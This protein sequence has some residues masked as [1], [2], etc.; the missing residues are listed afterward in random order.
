MWIKSWRLKK[1]DAGGLAQ[2]RGSGG[3]VMG[4]AAEGESRMIPPPTEGWVGGGGKQASSYSSNLAQGDFS[5][6]TPSR[7]KSWTVESD[8]TVCESFS[9]WLTV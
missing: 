5:G 7:G 1:V 3:K 8:S 2:G 4:E 9:H 6:V